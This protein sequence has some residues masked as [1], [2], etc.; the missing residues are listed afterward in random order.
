[1]DKK[2]IVLSLIGLAALVV[3]VVLLIVFTGNNAKQPTTSSE[4]RVIDPQAV[5]NV[6]NKFPTPPPVNIPSP[7]PS[8]RS[9]TP[10]SE[11][12]PAAR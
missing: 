7:S 2:K 4:Q 5:E 8:T 6:V 10:K 12:S 11:G 1:M 9:A 3:P